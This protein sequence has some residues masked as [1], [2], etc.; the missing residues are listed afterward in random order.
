[1]RKILFLLVLITIIFIPSLAFATQE[2]IKIIVNGKKIETKSPPLLI[3]GRL[4]V[5]YRTI[6]AIFGVE[7]G[8]RTKENILEFQLDYTEIKFKIGG[9]AFING[10]EIAMDV[11]A[12][13]V[14]N[15]HYVPLRLMVESF[16]S[17]IEWDGTNQTAKITTGTDKS[18]ERTI[19]L[20]SKTD[21][22]SSKH[23]GIKTRIPK[24]SM[25]IAAPYSDLALVYLKDPSK[26]EFTA[27]LQI[28]AFPEASKTFGN[29]KAEDIM[30]TYLKSEVIK[31]KGALGLYFPGG[32]EI[33]DEKDTDFLGGKAREIIYRNRILSE[34]PYSLEKQ[35]QFKFI[36]V[37]LTHDDVFYQ[38]FLRALDKDF[39]LFVPAYYDAVKSFEVTSPPIIKNSEITP[40]QVDITPFTG[41]KVG[42]IGTIVPVVKSG[43]FVGSLLSKE[44]EIKINKGNPKLEYKEW[45][46]FRYEV[47][48]E[49]VD[50]EMTLFDNLKKAREDFD[51]EIEY[52]QSPF[53]NSLLKFFGWDNEKFVK[54]HYT[55]GGEG[56]NRYCY[57]FIQQNRTDPECGL[58]KMDSY[59]STV[60]IQKNN[61]VI[62]LHEYNEKPVSS[63]NEVIKVLADLL[64]AP[65]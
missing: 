39:D 18:Q 32:I 36:T 34:Y 35:I 7:P 52:S 20:D 21:I 16:G 64:S 30:L 8:L 59:S 37:G 48:D 15:E 46:L 6:T 27:L 31:E 55:Y 2:E 11:P 9:N 50:V 51:E 49:S 10:E 57:S 17:S 1:M 13:L 22:Y 14:N 45:A 62:K 47:E 61:L 28:L 3:D 33:L 4:M 60:W 42:N 29:R 23:L 40:Q 26:G 43:K 38:I 54:E 25:V 12:Q 19:I 5:S 41:L 58:M 53:S 24:A 56:D 65:M 63:K 44:P